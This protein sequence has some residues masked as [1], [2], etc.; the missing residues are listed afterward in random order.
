MTRLTQRGLS[1]T[2]NQPADRP[3]AD[4][5]TKGGCKIQGIE[6]ATRVTNL[7]GR[8]AVVLEDRV[9]IDTAGVLN[10]LPPSDLDVME[11]YELNHE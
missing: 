11:Q 3:V 7:I 8:Q 6:N 5:L 10:V 2:V 9:L 4:Q 1:Y